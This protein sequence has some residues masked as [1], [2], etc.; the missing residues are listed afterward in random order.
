MS[1]TR[2]YQAFSPARCMATASMARMREHGLRYTPAKLLIDPYAKAITGELTYH[3][4]VYG[5]MYGNPYED[6]VPDVRD[7]AHTCRAAW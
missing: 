2:I 7:S 4:A 5:Y 3:N 6:L 1:G